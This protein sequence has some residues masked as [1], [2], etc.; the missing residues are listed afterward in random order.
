MMAI[1]NFIK[2]F[3]ANENAQTLTEYALIIMFVI[4]LV[5]VALTLFGNALFLTIVG[6]VGA[7][8]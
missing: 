8:F 1:L 6:A 4:I 2:I 5:V 3:I 7:A